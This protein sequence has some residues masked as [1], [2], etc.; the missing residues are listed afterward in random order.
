MK[1]KF[2]IN[3]RETRL[4]VIT[5]FI[6]LGL[7]W[8]FFSNKSVQPETQG[9]SEHSEQQ[10]IWTCSMHP[11]IK[12]DKP[13]QCPIC[14]MDLVPV[15]SIDSD[16]ELVSADEIQMSES[17][18]QLANIQTTLVARGVPQKSISLL[19]KVKPD[20]RNIAELTARFGGRIEKLFVNYTGQ[21]VSKGQ[22]MAMIYSPELITA[23]KELLEAVRFK[24]TNPAYYKAAVSKLKLW[25]LTNEQIENIIEKSE[26]EL[27]FNVLSPITG[28]VTQKYVSQG[29]YIKEGDGLFKVIDLANVWVMFEAYESDLPWIHTGDQ[30]EFT[31]QSLPGKSYKGKVTYIDPFIDPGTRV[32]KVRIELSNSEQALKPEMFANGILYSNAAGNSNELL[33]PKSSILWTG[34]RAVVYVKAGNKE[35]PSFQYREITLGP[36]AG[37]FYVAAKGLHEGEEIATNGVFKIDAAAQLAG[38]P[39]M[40]NPVGGKTST[41]HDHGNMDMKKGHDHSGDEMGNAE[42]KHESFKVSGN[43]EMCKSTIEKAAKSLPG[44]NTA[45]WN[46]ESKMLHVSFNQGKSTL[47][48][49]HKAIAQSGYDT[50]K[51]TAPK[52]AYDSLAPCCK[53]TRAS[54]EAVKANIKHVM[55]KVS[56]NCGMCKARIEKAALSLDGVN[57]ADWEKDTNMLHLSYNADKVKEMQIHKAIAQAGHDTEKETAPDSIYTN[58]PD[59]CKY[60]S[61]SSG[62]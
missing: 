21:R 18:V 31:I 16:E 12:Q 3:K 43:C 2:S 27:F 48:D 20:E 36:E 13:G 32:A 42:I 46:M 26:P 24:E 60:R 55:F 30:I 45:D 39:S 57:S 33:I 37:N 4:I 15:T 8:L 58:L 19:G 9:H 61:G 51:E 22:K 35:T 54:G 28:T 53:Y 14:G 44:V 40:M 7:G 56:G 62:P 23:Q 6:G 29:D 52:E 1:P 5:L 11:Q 17:A 38:K 47:A 50:E 34:K 41:G 10:T 25:D 59:C 49:I